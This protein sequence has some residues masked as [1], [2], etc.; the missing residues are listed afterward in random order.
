MEVFFFPFFFLI[1]SL[2]MW[3]IDQTVTFGLYSISGADT[4]NVHNKYI[5][6]CNCS[7]ATVTRFLKLASASSLF[8]LLM[9]TMKFN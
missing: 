1:Y 3:Y 4:E 5:F 6:I 8:C 7:A 2:N 9:T